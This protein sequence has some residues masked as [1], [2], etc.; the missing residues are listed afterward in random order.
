MKLAVTVCALVTGF[1]SLARGE[2][3]CAS[4]TLASY[5]ALGTAGCALGSNLLS[6]LETLSGI[7]GSTPIS[8]SGINI[9]PVMNAGDVGLMF[10]L[11][12]DAAGGSILEAL[13]SYKVSDGSYT[14]SAISA[15]G[16]STSGN[17]AVTDIQN[18]CLGGLFGPD[19]VSG[20]STGRTGSLL[21]L[22]DGSTSTSFGAAASLSITDDIT[23]DSGGSGNGNSASGGVFTDSFASTAASVPEPRTLIL[24]I[25]GAFTA[26][27]IRFTNGN[28]RKL[29]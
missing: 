17:G 1:A 19:G 20:C 11:A 9:T 28:R 25:A 4:G 3:M 10:S 21:L 14:A 7:N 26:A 18:L 13:I 16:T 8:P 29:L 27:L 24:L 2:P 15:S 5:I 6:G 12:S 22:G 23:F